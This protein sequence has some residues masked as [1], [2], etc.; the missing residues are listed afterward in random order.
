MANKRHSQLLDAYYTAKRIVLEAGFHAEIEWQRARNL[1]LLTEPEFLREAAW[2]ILASGMKESVIRQRFGAV[3]RAFHE[4]QSAQAITERSKRCFI[5]AM[6]VFAHAGKN[7]AIVEIAKIV[8]DRGFAAI[9]CEI[10]EHSVEFLQ[11]LPYIG[12]ITSYHLAKNIGHDVVKPDRHLVRIAEVCGYDSPAQLCDQIASMSED[13]P[14]VIDI[15]LWRFATL[16]S[17]YL[18][19]FSGYCCAPKWAA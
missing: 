10:R 3:S 2:V 8:A 12:P 5:K 6:K 19:H 1:E 16:H 13:R 15:V 7:A 17:G 9:K 4:W 11:T 14:C 18:A